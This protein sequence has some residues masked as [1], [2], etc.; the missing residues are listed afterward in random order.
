MSARNVTGWAT[1]FAI[2]ALLTSPKALADPISDGTAM[3]VRYC[4]VGFLGRDADKQKNYRY[5]SNSVLKDKKNIAS[6]SPV[7]LSVSQ[8]ANPKLKVSNANNG[9]NNYSLSYIVAAEKFEQQP[10]I[11]PITHKKRYN[12]IYTVIINTVVFDLQNSQIIGIYPWVYQ[13][14]EASDA[15]LSELEITKRFADFFRKPEAVAGS[16]DPSPDYML[17]AW[18]KSVGGLSLSTKMKTISA[19]PVTF[20][21]D[22][23]SA[24][25]STA[26]HGGTPQISTLSRNL[27]TQYEAILSQNF[28]LPIVPSGAGDQFVAS[29][30]NCVGQGDVSLRLPMPAYRFGFEVEQ[31]KTATV[32]HSVKRGPS[33][34]GGT[35][36]Q[37]E[38]GYGA[39]VRVTVLQSDELDTVNGGK[40]VLDNRVRLTSSKTFV[41]NREFIDSAQY[42][43][44]LVNL[45]SQTVNNFN[46]PQEKWLKDHLSAEESKTKPSAV[47]AAWTKLF[48]EKIGSP[49]LS[50]GSK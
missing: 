6:I 2:S 37:N 20:S 18:A 49:I 10:Y 26:T 34:G 46:N 24:L 5:L 28:A 16:D 48:K 1:V 40:T 44:L 4:G 13:F 31:L 33:G 38:V 35:V 7:L 19:A 21:A 11:Y 27:T 47:R 39:R 9:S 17:A 41:G 30:P 32:T 29:I 3:S 12:N 36:D 14:N 43:K 45:M 8:N 15:Q 22:A 23:T 50:Q 25:N 42:E